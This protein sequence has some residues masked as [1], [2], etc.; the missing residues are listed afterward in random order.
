MA[1]KNI[2]IT[3]PKPLVKK[4]KEYSG[5]TGRTFSSLVRISVEKFLEDEKNG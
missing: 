4:A 1:F 2:S 5:Q 3:L